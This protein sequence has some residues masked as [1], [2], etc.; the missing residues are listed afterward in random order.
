MELAKTVGR[1]A[2]AH[3]THD[4]DEYLEVDL[5]SEETDRGRRCAAPASISAAAETEAQTVALRQVI[6][7]ARFPW[8]VGAMQGSPAEETASLVSLCG[9]IAVDF[10]QERPESGI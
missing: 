1:G 3:R 9:K 8:V 7:T 4:D 2:L 10:K 5:R 6:G